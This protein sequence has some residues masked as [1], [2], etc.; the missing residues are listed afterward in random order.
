[1]RA[2]LALVL[3]C[4]AC[5]NPT[6]DLAE[7]PDLEMR[8]SL[9]ASVLYP[10][11][12]T[13]YLVVVRFTTSDAECP[14]IRTPPTLTLNGVSIDADEIVL[15]GVDEYRI[16]REPELRS[17]LDASVLGDTSIDVVVDDGSGPIHATIADYLLSGTLSVVEP[18]DAMLSSAEKVRAVWTPANLADVRNDTAAVELR[19]LDGS[20]HVRIGS[21]D[22]LFE[23]GEV[24][25]SRPQ[26]PL[27]WGPSALTLY[28]DWQA[29][30]GDR[31]D[32][33]AACTFTQRVPGTA[34]V[35]LD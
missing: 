28:L 12:T 30:P 2:A 20:G 24:R 17:R 34:I 8:T 19:E 15:G 1:M 26:G 23:G 29:V 18:A 7:L 21:Q 31:C 5:G 27:W 10:D 14:G 4:G 33:A 11:L 25:F 35:E 6:A 9:Y 13:Q 16:C 32:G 22:L 3:A